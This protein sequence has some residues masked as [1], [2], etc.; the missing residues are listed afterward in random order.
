MSDDIFSEVPML[1]IIPSVV[2]GIYIFYSSTRLVRYLPTSLV[3]TNYQGFKIG[4]Q[5]ERK[6]ESR[7]VI[8]HFHIKL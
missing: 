8:F 7:I 2:V 4:G 5:R 6:R 1:N 3:Y